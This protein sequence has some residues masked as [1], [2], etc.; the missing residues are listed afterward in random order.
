MT[1]ERER[2]YNEG[3]DGFPSVSPFSAADGLTPTQVARLR[4][5]LAQRPRGLLLD[6]DGTISPIAPTPEAA[7]LLPGM[8][9]LLERAA[10][11]FD[12]LAVVSGRGAANARRMVG[13]ERLLYIGNHGMERWLPGESAPEIV[14]AVLPYLPAIAQALD[15]AERDLTPRLPGVRIE[16]KGISGSVHTRGCADPQQ[17]LTTVLETLRPLTARLGLRLTEGKLVAEIRPPLAVHKGT[18]VEGVVQSRGLRSA[19]YLGDDTTDIDAFRALRR[20]REAGTCAG[21]AVAV[22]QAEAPP[23]L[24]AEADLALPS[25]RAVPAF[26]EWVLAAAS[27]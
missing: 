11:A 14:P 25:I 3:R 6:I 19:I 20:L 1:R 12:V 21:L 5:T 23:A 9:V 16:R 7:R 8:P 22:L 10:D 27:V 26:L 17:A 2:E 18:A 15:E 13:V 4:Q 24:A